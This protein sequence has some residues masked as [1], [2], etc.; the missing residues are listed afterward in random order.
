M[1]TN[2]DLIQIEAASP[3]FTGPDT[4]F[5][6]DKGIRDTIG[7]FRVSILSLGLALA[8]VKAE[9]LFKTLGYKSMTSYIRRLSDE[10]Q[11]DRSSVFNWLYMGQAYIKYQAELEEAGF[12]DND[13]P[14]KLP[15]LERAL[16]K[17]KRQEVFQNIKTMSVREFASYAKGP[18]ERSAAD[19][20][21]GEWV[22][23]EKGC[24]FYVNGMLAVT[25]SGKINRRVSA[26][27]KKTLRVACENLEQEGTILPIQLRNRRD[28]NRFG[29]AVEKLRIQMGIRPM[30]PRK[31]EPEAFLSERSG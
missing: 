11:M 9:G 28:A 22:T 2:S 6:I 31:T 30:P 10:C 13:G 1:G 24:N 26:Y 29:P 21:P 8:K 3:D 20:Y 7:G 23:A 25:V 19:E 12:G 14:T 15:Y 5:E 17:N 4:A 27:L 18:I 16:A